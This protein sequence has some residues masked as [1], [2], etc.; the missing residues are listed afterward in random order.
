M[1]PM[2]ISRWGRPAR[3]LYRLSLPCA[4]ALWL[5]PLLAVLVTSIRSTDEIMAGHYWDWPKQ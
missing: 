2:P 4:L 1:Y 5:V 3:W